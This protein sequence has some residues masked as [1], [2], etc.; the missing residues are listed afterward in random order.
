MQQYRQATGDANKGAMLD[1]VED[2]TM[3]VV[4]SAVSL[5]AT[6]AGIVGIAGG[7]IRT[8]AEE[9]M[10]NPSGSKTCVELAGSRCATVGAVA[11]TSTRVDTIGVNQ[12]PWN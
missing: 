6:E 7:T 8:L 9:T 11:V 5:W 10:G 4:V 3:V 1:L 2:S 12:I